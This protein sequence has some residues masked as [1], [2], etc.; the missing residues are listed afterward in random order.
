MKN[1]YFSKGPLITVRY[2]YPETNHELHMKMDGMGW[3]TFSFP[4]GMAYVQGPC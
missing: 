1:H 4:V 3:K 2:Y